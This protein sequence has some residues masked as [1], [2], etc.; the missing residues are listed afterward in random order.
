MKS[1]ETG[2]CTFTDNGQ[3]GG[4]GLRFC[5]EGRIRESLNIVEM[6]CAQTYHKMLKVARVR[7]A[8]ANRCKMCGFFSAG[9]VRAEESLAAAPNRKCRCLLQA[10][11]DRAR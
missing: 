10:D 7:E 9:A 11:G 6:I 4:D 5:I 2:N 1:N 8:F 3:L